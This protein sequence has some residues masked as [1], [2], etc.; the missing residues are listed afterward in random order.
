MQL[1]H[2]AEE[3]TVK[4]PISNIKPGSPPPATSTRISTRAN[5]KPT[6][7]LLREPHPLDAIFEPKSVAVI[8]ATEATG[9]VG[10]TI[11]ENL[12][13]S[14]FKGRVYPVNPKRDTVLGAKAW[15]NVGAIPDK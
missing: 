11:I 4:K 10:R 7:L 14:P 9:S 15:P 6:S 12:L 5:A 8:G 3:K 13:K 2:V 1:D